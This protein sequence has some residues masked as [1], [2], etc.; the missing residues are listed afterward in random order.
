M[1]RIRHKQQEGAMNLQ[2]HYIGPGHR[3][4]AL[5][6]SRKHLADKSL[7]GRKADMLNSAQRAEG[8]PAGAC[9][10]CAAKATEASHGR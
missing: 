8:V 5:T 7:C 3:F 10:R 9:T 2:W 6:V 1:Q 4:H